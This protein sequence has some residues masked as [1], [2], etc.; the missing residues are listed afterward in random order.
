M[1]DLDNID[2]IKKLDPK[3]VLGSTNLFTAQCDQILNESKLSYPDEYKN[4]KNVIVCGMGGSAYGGYV[5]QTLFKDS[6]KVPVISNNDYELPAFAS[7]DSLILLSSYSGTTEE[8]LACAR[9]A[10]SKGFRITGICGGGDLARFLKEEKVPH[11]EFDPKNNPS[12]QPRLGTGY[13]VLGTI[14]IMNALGFINVSDDEIKK[15]VEF[16]N[17]SKERISGSA[18]QLAENIQGYIPLVFSGSIFE[19]N[20]H[21]LRNQF[22]ETA[23]SFSSFHFLPEANHHVL[24][25][26]KNPTERKITALFL[27]SDLYG[28]KISKRVVLTKDVVKKNKTPVLEYRLTGNSKF[29]QSLEILAFGGYVTFYLA[30]LYG[31][32]PSLIPWV[33]YFKEQLAK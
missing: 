4:L 21:I 12:G 17:Q 8:V 16:I 11:I 7:S 26:L 20:I 13:M 5:V 23:K 30:I 3:D 24:E 18:K 2:E 25:G 29:A 6:L 15:A 14:V 22:N 27:D 10:K 32:D 33:D 9:E 19:G 28:E 1:I 31:Q